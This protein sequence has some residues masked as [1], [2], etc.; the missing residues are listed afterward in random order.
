MTYSI[1]ARDPETGHLGVAVQ[2][3]NF[4]TGTWVPWAEGG[5]G[6]IAT[7]ALAERRYGFLGLDLIRDGMTAH[8]ALQ[9][10]L[11]ADPKRDFRQVSMIDH[12]GHIATHTGQRCFPHAGSYM[13]DTF[14][15]QANMMA[16][17]TVWGAMASAYETASG[18]LANH[19]LD[20]MQSFLDASE[21]GR[22]IELTTTCERPAAFPV[23][24]KDGD[25]DG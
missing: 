20:I 21:Q 18:D 11:A 10:L 19:V 2:T 24:L 16:R 4:A 25:L 22:H 6:A 15:A 17:D 1:V 13:G 9:A 12:R 8:E 5:V 3:F 23:G 7:Q 14:C